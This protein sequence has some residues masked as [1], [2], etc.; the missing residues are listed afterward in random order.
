[1]DLHSEAESL[2]AMLGC[3]KWFH[4]LCVTSETKFTELSSNP[5]SAWLCK[6]CSAL[7]CFILSNDISSAK[8]GS[9]IGNDIVIQLNHIHS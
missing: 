2:G 7:P 4:P 9:H 6:N 8:W 1:M 5:N 3:N